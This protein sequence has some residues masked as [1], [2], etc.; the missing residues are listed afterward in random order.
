MRA[1]GRRRVAKASL[2]SPPRLGRAWSICS[3]APAGHGWE[4]AERAQEA[5]PACP[6][7]MEVPSGTAART[8]AG[9]R[10]SAEVGAWPLPTLGSEQRAGTRPH[11]EASLQPHRPPCTEDSGQPAAG[12]RPPSALT[13]PQLRPS[14]LTGW[15]SAAGPR[16]SRHRP[17]AGPH[18]R[19]P[20]CC[21]LHGRTAAPSPA[22]QTP[23]VARRPARHRNRSLLVGKRSPF[24]PRRAAERGCGKQGDL[25]FGA[26]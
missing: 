9:W 12:A 10:G 18:P 3:L 15:T 6:P 7:E 26:V 24:P 8:P 13:V 1:Q 11:G 20:L 21:P 5:G 16:L 17:P 19:L 4:G 14:S 23:C 22:E 25:P 2:F